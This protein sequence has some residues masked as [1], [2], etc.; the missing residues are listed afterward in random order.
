MIR[1]ILIFH[2]VLLSINGF[3]QV[4]NISAKKLKTSKYAG[5]YAYGKNVEHEKVGT[6]I[7]YPDTDSTVLFYFESNTGPSAF[8][9]G[10]YYGRVKILN[11]IGVLNTKL[12]NSE[13]SCQWNFAFSKKTVLIQ[14]IN[15]ANDCGFPKG[16]SIDGNYNRQIKGI[17]EECLGLHGDAINFAALKPETYNKK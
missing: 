13:K 14:A 15:N 1:A 10:E 9:M 3:S 5:L 4:T 8:T 2:I 7:I 17:I 16:I 12:A 6:I 11:G